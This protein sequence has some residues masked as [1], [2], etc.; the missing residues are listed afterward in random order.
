M[1]ATLFGLTLLVSAAAL[2]QPLAELSQSSQQALAQEQLHNQQRQARFHAEHRQAEQLLAQ[3]RRALSELQARVESLS[4]SF[5]ANEQALADTEQQL[6]LASSSLG[7]LYG[8]VR[9]AGGEL[10]RELAQGPGSLLQPEHRE[11]ALRLSKTDRLPSLPQLQQMVVL[12]NADIEASKRVEPVTMAVADR[13]GQVHDQQVWRLGHFNLVSEQGYLQLNRERGLV[14]VYPRQP[15]GVAVPTLTG[16]QPLLL[17]PAQGELLTQMQTTP[18]LMQRFEQGGLVGKGIALLLVIGGV[19][20]LA[21]MLVLARIQLRINRQLAK[22]QQ[23][24][25]NPL[26]RILSVYQQQRSQSLDT[27][28]LKLTEA[29]VT[30][31]QGLE[32]GLSMLKLMAAIAPMMGLLGTVTGMIGTFQTITQFGNG[33]PKIMA[34]GIS[35]ALVTTVLGLMAAIPLLLAHNLLSSR[36]RTIRSILEKESIALVAQH[37]ERQSPVEPA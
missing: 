25:D 9:Q 7:E 17:D 19:I 31:Q 30:Q 16:W 11:Q 20:A 24:S 23:P 14:S 29:I 34:G 3:Q 32:K 1:K 33:D 13:Q 36:V 6:A 27:L 5:A 37:A 15:N 12:L 4:Q 18:T 26:G 10:Q 8:V 2:A 28:E 35:M 22:P 21:R